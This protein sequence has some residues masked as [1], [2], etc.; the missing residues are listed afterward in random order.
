MLSSKLWHKFL[1]YLPVILIL[2]MVSLIY[3]TYLISYIFI[4]ISTD[5]NSDEV[6]VLSHTSNP[7]NALVKGYVL[8]VMTLI[9]LIML[10]WAILKTVTTDPGYFP[11]P[12][13]L[14]YK[15]I[16][17][18]IN[19]LLGSSNKGVDIL[20][21]KDSPNKYSKN[22]N[23]EEIKPQSSLQKTRKLKDKDYLNLEQELEPDNNYIFESKISNNSK[24]STNNKFNSAENNRYFGYNSIFLY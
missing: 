14:E 8:F 16:S 5:A 6:Y 22:D 13:D 23:G 18:S 7:S 21:I 24:K 10:V 12:M 1:I 20:D 2:L 19:N 15:L 9:F 3:I 11:E 17:D 4:L